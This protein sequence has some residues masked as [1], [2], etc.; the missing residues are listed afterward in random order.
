MFQANSRRFLRRVGA[1]VECLTQTFGSLY[2]S[3]ED[4]PVPP[5]DLTN[6]L[7]TDENHCVSFAQLRKEN[8]KR[9][10]ASC[11]A[12]C[13]M[14]SASARSMGLWTSKPAEFDATDSLKCVCV[15]KKMLNGS[16][17]VRYRQKEDNMAFLIPYWY[18][19]Q[20]QRILQCYVF[21]S[22]RTS[23]PNCSVTFTVYWHNQYDSV[24]LR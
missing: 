2:G 7:K 9:I 6:P 11:G 4:V 5:T 16:G 18:L 17:L 13:C 19:R 22:F 12:L 8:W 24:F 21:W 20:T 10:P 14:T 15:T 1:I 23:L 3:V